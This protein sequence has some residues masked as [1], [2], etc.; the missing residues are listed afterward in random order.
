MEDAQVVSGVYDV[1]V[2]GAGIMG[3]CTA[4]EV[5]KR[6]RSVMLL[7]QFDFLH[8]RGSSHGESRTIRAT[9][10]E[11][12]YT[13]MMQEAFELWEQAQAE[14][15]YMVHTKTCHLDFGPAEN[16]SLHAV[17]SACKKHGVPVEILS[18]KE[19][20]HRF[21][22]FQLPENWVA[23]RTAKGG[24]LH[25]SKAVAMFQQL[26]QKNGAVLRDRTKILRIH[27]GWRLPSGESGVLVV[28]GRGAALGRR[29]ILTAGSWTNKIV[30]ELSGFELPIQPLHTTYAY[31]AIGKD[32]SDLF[33]VE[34]GFPTF[35]CYGQPYI[36]GSPSL[37]YPGLV[38]ISLHSGS[39]CDADTRIVAPDWKPLKEIVSPWIASH[40]HGKVKHEDPVMAEACIYSMTP[41]QDFILDFLP[42]PDAK[43]HQ[44][45]SIL[46]AAGFSGH[47]F[48]MGPLIGRVMADLAIFGTSSDIP[49]EYFTLA[50]FCRHAKGG[51]RVSLSLGHEHPWL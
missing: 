46:V 8:R 42:V 49:L 51:R 29:C 28:T 4:Y 16:K 39:P 50:R 38:K 17:I 24:V 36:Y 2:V 1:V 30:K 41:D 48:K 15:G 7:E 31:W 11:D 3:S 22:V 21:D 5:A 13:A 34:K 37:E 19:V 27:P 26:A 25:A 32:H 9:Y 20:A 44:A 33:S 47:G 18:S 45:G 43:E 6:S 12:Y 14:A 35:A 23:L 40:M 10:P